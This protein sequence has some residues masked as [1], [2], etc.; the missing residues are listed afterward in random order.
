MNQILRRALWMAP[1]LAGILGSVLGARALKQAMSTCQSLYR[2]DNAGSQIESEL[3]FETQESRRAFLY[4][5]TIRDP[6]E[7]LPHIDLAR[8]ASRRVEILAHR[9]RQLGVP[10]IGAWVDGFERAW[11]KYVVAR[12]EIVADILEGNIA[13]SIEVEG[14]EG[15]PAFLQALW[16]LHRLK[17]VLDSHARADSA[18]VDSTLKRCAAGLAAF[19]ICMLLV[20]VLLGQANRERRLALESLHANNLVLANAQKME[21][22]RAAILEMVSKHASLPRTLTEIVEMA[23]QS[24]ADAGAAVWAAAGEFLHF[25]VAANLPLKLVKPLKELLLPR[26]DAISAPSAELQMHRADL[27]MESGLGVTEA[28]VL[29]DAGGRV[30]G[31]LQ[32]F[33]RG[34]SS[35]VRGNVV[36]QMAHLAAVGIENT[37]LYERLAFQA[38][39]DTLTE[40]PNRMLFQDRVQQALQLARRHR[41]K[42]AVLWIDL[43][44][45][46][47]INDALGHRVGDEVLREVAMRLRSCLRESD[48]VA[49]VGGDEFTVLAHDI[50]STPAADLVCHKILK[51][52]SEPMVCGEHSVAVS[53]SI[54]ISIFPEH[55]EDPITLMRHADL[56]MYIAKRNGGNAHHMF[57]PALG[58]NMQRRLQL[59]QELASALENEEFTLYYQ[60]LTDRNGRL[61]GLEALLRWTSPALGRIS[62]ADFIPIAE[63]MGLIQK[64]GE[65]VLQTACRTGARW[66]NAGLVV[67]NIAVNVSAVQFVARDLASLVERTLRET[68]FPARKLVLEITE[69]ALMNN[70]EQALEQM[71]SLRDLGVRFA[72]DDF[73]T[74]YSSLS[75]L[76]NLPVD[77]LKIDR[78]FV[79]DL[80]SS[81]SG[82]TTLVRGIIGLAH[83]LQLEVVAEGVETQEQ[84]TMLGAMGCDINQGFLL[85][86]PMPSEQVEAL[87]EL[88]SSARVDDAPVLS[89]A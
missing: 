67:P 87:L 28:R 46:K 34:A 31:M 84:L 62:P 86:K 63:E 36:D 26:N 11:G 54:G 12:D 70:I 20:V 44:R 19:A 43:D 75:Q 45:Y 57:S 48:T 65:W 69:T 78:S 3:E 71:S 55:G 49:R 77:C 9:I 58:D 18:L 61:A 17:S 66:L 38:Q 80:D 79:K 8:A 42:A 51:A 4:A 89:T 35:A 52:L 2:V 33:A 64:I 13:A 24:S 68:E 29:H 41:R 27:A 7:Q 76:R 88:H 73:G 82:S 72:I 32:V 25:Q 30:I 10:E 47:Q 23:P 40:L 60:P 6:N 5:M 59:E 56:A 14:T 15:Q 50:A 83:S 16:S 21:Q 53:G 1:A 39:H 81:G 22:Q 37:L 85:Y 74:G